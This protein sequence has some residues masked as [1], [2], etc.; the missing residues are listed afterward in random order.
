MF[1][2]IYDIP[3]YQLAIAMAADLCRILLGRSHLD[4]ALD[5]TVRVASARGHQ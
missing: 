1:Y 3:T 4:P 2:W 5:A